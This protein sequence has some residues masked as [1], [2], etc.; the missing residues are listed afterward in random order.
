MKIEKYMCDIKNC[1]NEARSTGVIVSVIRNT[2]MGEGILDTAKMDICET[3][4]SNIISNRVI[5]LLSFD[6]TFSER[7]IKF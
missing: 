5:P 4:L 7:E 1:Q 2:Q 3:C 6:N